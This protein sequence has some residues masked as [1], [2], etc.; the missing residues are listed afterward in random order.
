MFCKKYLLIK[1]KIEIL[2]KHGAFKDQIENYERSFDLHAIRCGNKDN[3]TEFEEML[4]VYGF[5]TQLD[6]IAANFPTTVFRDYNRIIIG[7]M[8]RVKSNLCGACNIIMSVKDNGFVCEQ[9]GLNEIV[10]HVYIGS[11]GTKKSYKSRNAINSYCEEWLN[12]LQGKGNANLPPHVFDR[13]VKLG[14]NKCGGQIHRVNEITCRTIRQWLKQMKETKYNKFAVNILRQVTRAL[15]NEFQSVSFNEEER[16]AII[17]DWKYLSATYNQEYNR[18]KQKNGAKKN[19]NS[20]Y[21]VL[22]L[23]IAEMR[24]AKDSEKLKILRSCV[25]TQSINT[26]TV[27]LNAF[28]STCMKLNYTGSGIY[29]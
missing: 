27:R 22:L 16:T 4:S 21:P 11:S 1:A 13:L 19:N 6:I 2:K 26:Y 10:Q 8:E 25:Y 14:H 29:A 7:T 23:F 3:E 15:G 28:R 18:L 9:C 20:Y 5:V 12:Y 24:L 17:S